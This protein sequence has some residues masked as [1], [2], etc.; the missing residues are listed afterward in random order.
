MPDIN[1]LT[2]LLATAKMDVSWESEKVSLEKYS[3][4]SIPI[5]IRKKVMGMR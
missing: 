5:S 3:F 2:F 4:G 1:A